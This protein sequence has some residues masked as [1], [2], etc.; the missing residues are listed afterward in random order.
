MILKISRTNAKRIAD[1]I[2]SYSIVDDF[3]CGFILEYNKLT[4]E[5]AFVNE[6]AKIKIDRASLGMGDKI[7]C[8]CK[9]FPNYPSPEDGQEIKAIKS[10]L[11]NLKEYRKQVAHDRRFSLKDKKMLPGM[12]CPKKSMKSLAKI[13]QLY[14]KDF[15][16]IS[17]ALKAYYSDWDYREYYLYGITPKGEC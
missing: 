3:L 15:K 12:K 11:C 5:K 13:H 6:A 1:I 2:I 9:V 17:S 10:K 4:S 7:E 8:F 14:E 16:A